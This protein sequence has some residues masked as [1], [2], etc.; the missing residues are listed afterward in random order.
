MTSSHYLPRRWSPLECAMGFC[1]Q[2][3]AYRRQDTRESPATQKIAQH[4]SAEI[5]GLLVKVYA[6]SLF[7][8]QFGCLDI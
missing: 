7:V 2:L 8:Q 5:V 6:I 3:Y 4:C 1:R